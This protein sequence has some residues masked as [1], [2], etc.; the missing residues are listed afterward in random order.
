MRALTKTT[1]ADNAVE[2]IRGEIIA[3]RWL[4]GEKLPN[5]ASLSSMLSV[6]R[7]TIREAVRV[8]VSQGFLE[9]RQGSGTYVRSVTDVSRPLDM[10]RRAGLRDQFEARLALEVEAARLAALR[11]SPEIV[12]QLRALLIARGNYT[13]GDK[14]AFIERDLA[15]HK[16][17]VAASQNRAMIELYEFFSLSIAETI[18]ATLGADIPEPDMQAHIAIVDAIET[19]NPEAADAAVRRFMAPVVATLDRLLMS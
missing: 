8:L 6:S 1:L 10:A 7:G 16:A 14:A 13:G 15:F 4:V 11:H 18:E 17:V 3:R 9:T 12:S 19:G 5:E 2:A